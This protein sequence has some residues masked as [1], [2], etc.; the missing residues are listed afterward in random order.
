MNSEAYNAQYS[1]LFCFCP[2]ELFNSYLFILDLKSCGWVCPMFPKYN[3]KQVSV[4]P[5]KV[6]GTVGDVPQWPKYL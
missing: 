3:I 2:I 6:F 4:Q 5:H 1:D